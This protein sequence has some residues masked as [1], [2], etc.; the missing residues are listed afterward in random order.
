MADPET[1][2]GTYS[3]KTWTWKGEFDM[4]GKKVATRFVLVES[5]PTVHTVTA[6]MSEDG[7]KWTTLM[8]GKSTKQ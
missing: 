5:S 1:A 6:S 7:K 2:T 3:G 8:E 4:G